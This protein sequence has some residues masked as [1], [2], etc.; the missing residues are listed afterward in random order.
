M[1][2]AEAPHPLSNALPLCAFNFVLHP[3]L[4]SKELLLLRLANWH[5][6]LGLQLSETEHFLFALYVPQTEPNPLNRPPFSLLPTVISDARN[7]F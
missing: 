3:F 7:S 4:L 5:S 6:H 2:T 1:R